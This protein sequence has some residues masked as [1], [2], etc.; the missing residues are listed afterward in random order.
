MI[1]FDNESYGDRCI[2]E[3]LGSFILSLFFNTVP[4]NTFSVFEQLASMLQV[5][6]EILLYVFCNEI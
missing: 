2:C 6:G 4:W 5:F 1:C 3:M